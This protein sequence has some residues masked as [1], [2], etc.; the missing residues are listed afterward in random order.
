MDLSH[1]VAGKEAV[2]NVVL[3][4]SDSVVDIGASINILDRKWLV[5]QNRGD[6][7]LCVRGRTATGVDTAPTASQVINDG[8]RIAVGDVIWFPISENFN[9]FACS[10]SGN[11]KRVSLTEFA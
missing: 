7:S 10:Q 6:V 11:G 9:L 5:V 3:V 1:A 4:H 8:I 2:T